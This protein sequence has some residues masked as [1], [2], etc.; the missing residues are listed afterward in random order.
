[1]NYISVTKAKG[2]RVDSFA[3]NQLKSLHT[4]FVPSGDYIIEQK[5]EGGVWELEIRG[6]INIKSFHDAMDAIAEM[7]PTVSMEVHIVCLQ[8][9]E[10]DWADKWEGGR[11]LLQVESDEDIS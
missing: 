9:S 4:L 2:T 1:M 3:I 7:A 10:H 6:E 5:R 8:G 11:K